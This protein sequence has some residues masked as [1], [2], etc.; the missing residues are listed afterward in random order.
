M[1]ATITIDTPDMTRRNVERLV[2]CI[3]MNVQDSGLV[4]SPGHRLEA[5]DSDTGSPIPNP[6]VKPPE[7]EDYDDTM[8]HMEVAMT[9]ADDFDPADTVA[10]ERSRRAKAWAEVARAEANSGPKP[11]LDSATY[12]AQ[13]AMLVMEGEA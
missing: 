6:V 11:D 7:A 4:P 9:D 5:H 2:E 12:A 10:A 3:Q 8:N 13:R 1:R